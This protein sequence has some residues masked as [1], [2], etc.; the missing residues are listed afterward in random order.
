MH[1]VTAVT[2][3]GSCQ[4][5]LTL[6][7]PTLPNCTSFKAVEDRRRDA[8]SVSLTPVVQI[9]RSRLRKYL[10]DIMHSSLNHGKQLGFA[11]MHR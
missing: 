4:S 6:L 8:S 5:I 9:A 11:S 3:I 7:G 10:C 2:L 1:Q